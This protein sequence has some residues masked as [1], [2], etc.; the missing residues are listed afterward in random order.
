MQQ[1]DVAKLT[2]DQ[3]ID[4]KFLLRFVNKKSVEYLEML[5]SIEKTGL[6]NSICVRPAC[7]DVR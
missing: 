4:P 6:W 3:I 7:S 5:D 1:E 2:L